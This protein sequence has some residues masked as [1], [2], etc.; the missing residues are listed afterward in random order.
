MLQLIG[1][2]DTVHIG[3]FR[4]RKHSHHCTDAGLGLDRRTAEFRRDDAWENDLARPAR[5]ITSRHGVDERSLLPL[6][7]R[8]D[9]VAG[10]GYLLFT[11]GS[12]GRYE[13]Q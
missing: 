2:V 10:S 5:E 1:P 4:Y 3:P 12:E 9:A 11:N 6:T 8:R 13:W 7:A